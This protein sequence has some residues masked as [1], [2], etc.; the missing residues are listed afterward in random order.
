M[1]D[2]EQFRVFVG[3]LSWEINDRELEDEFRRFGKV[4]DAKV[5]F[6]RN[7]SVVLCC[8]YFFSSLSRI[9]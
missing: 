6:L 4:L 7:I 8:G 3:G 9:L 1:S 2:Y 5:S